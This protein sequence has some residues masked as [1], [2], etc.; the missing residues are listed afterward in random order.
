MNQKDINTISIEIVDPVKAIEENWTKNYF[1]DSLYP[2]GLYN[3][4]PRLKK[5][6]KDK[7]IGKLLLIIK[8]FP[9]SKKKEIRER[10]GTSAQRNEEFSFMMKGEMIKY[11]RKEG[12][13]ITPLGLT[14][15][16]KFNLI[17]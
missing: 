7:G 17:S 1:G 2:I 8:D 13:E 12:Y 4:R 14:L 6:S 15:L 9:H 5:L 3:Y 11:S 10:M 16:R